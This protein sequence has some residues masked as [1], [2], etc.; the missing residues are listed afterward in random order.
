MS[1]PR[2]I[3]VRA[4]GRDWTDQ[5]RAQ[6]SDL[7]AG[8]VGGEPPVRPGALVVLFHLDIPVACGAHRWDAEM[9][10]QTKA[11]DEAEVG[12]SAQD[13][14]DWMKSL[15]EV[16]L[17]AEG[18]GQAVRGMLAALGF[19]AEASSLPVGPVA[20]ASLR[21][22]GLL[23]VEDHTPLPWGLDAPAAEGA[24]EPPAVTP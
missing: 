4:R 8:L 7:L 12:M 2:V 6:A 1:A 5:V 20:G 11:A 15:D 18:P 3:P 17:Y 21:R 13:Y 14:A 24:G 10:L 9:A 23:A 22:R 16:L 19:T